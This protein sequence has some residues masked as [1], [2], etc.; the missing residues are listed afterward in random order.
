MID[1]KNLESYRENNRIEAKKALGGFPQSVWETYSAFANTLG[2]IILLG[3]E[4]KKDHSLHAVDLPDP[5]KLIGEF[6]S[7]VNDT[8]KVSV[9]VLSGKDV[10]VELVDGKRI[11]VITVPRAQR[12]DRPVYIG[13]NA[14]VG[15]YRRNGEGDYRCSRD[16]IEAM[17]R[18]AAVKTADMRVING[19][20]LD[21]LYPDS[22][23]RY[24]GRL[25]K[26][27]LKGYGDEELLIKIGA[28]GR[29]GDEKTH[30]TA[31]GLIMF[32]DVKDV[33]K[34][35]PRY[36]LDYRD[37]G[38]RIS[39]S[40]GDW[41]GNVFDFYFSVGDK[42][43]RYADGDETVQGALKEALANC[44]VNADYYGVGGIKINNRKGRI[45]FSNPGGFRIDVNTAK[46]GGISDPRNGALVKMFNLIDVGG[47]TGSGIPHIYS[48]WKKRGWAAPAISESFDPERT[49]LTLIMGR[50]GYKKPT[51]NS[52]AEPLAQKAAIV[53]YLTDN[54]RGT[55]AEL[56]K[57]LG[58]K[59][60]RIKGL[61]SDLKGENLIVSE[62]SDGK[63]TYRLKR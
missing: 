59:S 8:D 44:L 46:N 40:S 56:C 38:E 47:G 22:L 26:R 17:L 60:N 5:D 29:G 57:R 15:S 63:I 6:W 55:E 1:F 31:A 4:E 25:N 30:P 7:V 33:S 48:V 41:S 27:G 53:E 21:A 14:M 39:S 35:Y 54:V 9:N 58:L 42:I 18:D 3:V 19:F 16:E 2:G 50:T 49:A 10:S 20:G 37:G 28:A 36:S 52:A 11:I 32:G 34:E 61:L 24:R 12:F 51:P 43:S 45:T 13:G 23:R 62:V